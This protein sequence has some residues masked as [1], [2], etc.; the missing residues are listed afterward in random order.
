MNIQDLMR[1]YRDGFLAGSDLKDLQ[2]QA[3]NLGYEL[4]FHPNC[5][6]RVD[7]RLDFGRD[8]HGDAVDVCATSLSG[9][10]KLRLAGYS[11]SA[12]AR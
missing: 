8:E 9:R 5:V 10:E 2:D 1:A 11:P 7:G 12:P 6:R 3:G 4:Q